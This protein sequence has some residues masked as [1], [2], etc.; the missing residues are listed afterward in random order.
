MYSICGCPRSPDSESPSLLKD[1]RRRTPLVCVYT[2]HPI[3]NEHFSHRG[4]QRWMVKWRLCFR[5]L[6]NHIIMACKAIDVLILFSIFM[7]QPQ[8]SMYFMRVS[9]DKLTQSA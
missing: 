2:F 8:T 9:C 1:E 7:L 3:H 6:A 4:K 5:D